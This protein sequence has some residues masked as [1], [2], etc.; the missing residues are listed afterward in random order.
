MVKF[1]IYLFCN[2]EKSKNLYTN[3]K[4][5]MQSGRGKLKKWVLE[6]GTKDTKIKSF[7]G[8]GK[9]YRYT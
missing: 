9:F 3:K 4:T 6:F 8:L 1:V 5:A 7:N 2:Y